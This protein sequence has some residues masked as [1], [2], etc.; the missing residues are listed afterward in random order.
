[1]TR[2]RQLFLQDKSIEGGGT[3]LALSIISISHLYT[4]I[5]EA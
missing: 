2:M 5:F 4:N 3:D 1:M